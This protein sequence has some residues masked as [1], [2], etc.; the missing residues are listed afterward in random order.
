V[1]RVP[2]AAIIRLP[3][4]ATE[5]DPAVVALGI[6]GAELT[7]FRIVGDAATPLGIGVLVDA[8]DV[9][10]ADLDIAGA[11]TAAIDI[12]A[13]EGVVLMGSDVHDNPGAAIRLRSGAAPRIA[14][15][16]FARNRTA[17]VATAVVLSDDASSPVWTRNVFIDLD[18]AAVA[19]ARAEAAARTAIAADNWFVAGR[20]AGAAR[21]A[22]GRGSRGR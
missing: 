21:P 10:L 7:G 13:G 8:A 5:G 12:A 17:A 16:T 22:P 4:G 3:G 19:G 11:A 14:H 15:N 1:S 9:R 20:G 6:R 18:P 2:R